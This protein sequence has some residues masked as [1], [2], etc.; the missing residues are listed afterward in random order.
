MRYNPIKKHA[1]ILNLLSI[2]SVQIRKVM[3]S[4]KSSGFTKLSMLVNSSLLAKFPASM[5]ILEGTFVAFSNLSAHT[6]IEL[7]L[8][9]V[10]K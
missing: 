7:R 9:T 2:L 3:V 1:G 10:T 8:C 5:I 6:A 4:K